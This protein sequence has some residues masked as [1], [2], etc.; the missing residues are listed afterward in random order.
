MRSGG[1]KMSGT[2]Y[3]GGRLSDG[4]VAVRFVPSTFSGIGRD[5]PAPEPVELA[6]WSE[7][8]NP[9]T[10]WFVVDEY[11]Q[12]RP[13]HKTQIRNHKCSDEVAYRFF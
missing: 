4:E 13:N 10:S 2:G 11:P 9:N 7:R 6:T 12:N 8:K 5:P 1:V 3:A